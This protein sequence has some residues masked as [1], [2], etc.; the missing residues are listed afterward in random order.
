MLGWRSFCLT[1]DKGVC[2]LVLQW[3][4]DLAVGVSLIDEQHQELFARIN[5]LLEACNQ[6]KGREEVANVIAFL[7]EYID[8]HFADEEALQREVAYPE[9]ANHKAMHESFVA[10][11]QRLQ[12]QLLTDGPTVRFV[13]QVNRKVVDWLVQHISKVDK[14]LAAYVHSR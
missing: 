2:H 1:S 8:L 14:A 10:D 9:Y 11:Y 4:E 13:L 6:G 12:Q 7:G 3:R 5:S